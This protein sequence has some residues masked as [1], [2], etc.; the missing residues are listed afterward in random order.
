MYNPIIYKDLHGYDTISRDIEN[1]FPKYIGK[2]N[3]EIK[4][5]VIVGGYRCWEA[6]FYLEKYINSVIHIFE[7]VEEY[8]TFL[9]KQYGQNSRCKLYNIAISDYTGFIDFYR[10]SSP[11]TDSMYPVIENNNSGYGFKSISK[12]K[13]ISQ[14]LSNI[15][16][17]DIDLLSI[18]VQGAEDK[19]LMGTNLD[20]VSCIFAE[21]QMSSNAQNAVY[22]GQCFSEDLEKIL[23][24]KFKLHSLGLDNEM[25]NGTGNSFWIN[26]KHV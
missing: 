24:D 19:V 5:I 3:N 1:N 21:I 23:L 10:T 16:T 26:L 2:Q 22:Q 25:K 18:D 7:P 9:Q 6:K 8:F 14:K 12:I 4:T 15:I 11:G 13:V 17:D 20:S